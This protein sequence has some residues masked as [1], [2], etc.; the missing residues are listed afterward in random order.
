MKL[1]DY[2]KKLGLNYHT[3]YRSYNRGEIDGAYSLPTGTIIVPD[4]T[5]VD[6]KKQKVVIYAR[7]S[8]SEN[9]K[10]L[11]SQAKRLMDFC[12]A[13]GYSVDKI[14]K[15][16]GSGVNDKRKK[17]LSILEDKS[18]TRIVVEHK[19]RLTRF[20]FNYIEATI[21]DRCQIEVVN[22]SIDQEQDIIQDFIAIITSF[23]ARIYGQRRS[24]RKT[25]KLIEE[26][27]ND[28]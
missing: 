11:E 6:S 16:I 8:S 28:S 13:K 1:S 17:L 10:N 19:D 4:K 3:L 27:S 25:E 15:E 22:S 23:C 14:V 9:K 21:K 2:A 24:K 5:D 7:V 12:C 18:I 20:G 26:L